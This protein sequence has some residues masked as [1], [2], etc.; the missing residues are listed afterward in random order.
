MEYYVLIVTILVARVS[1]LQK[2]KDEDRI[3]GG[4]YAKKGEFPYAVV[5]SYRPFSSSCGGGI[6]SPLYVLTACHCT[7]T[8]TDKFGSLPE[9]KNGDYSNTRV[10]AGTLARDTPHDQGYQLRWVFRWIQHPQCKPLL[11]GEWIF[12]IAVIQVSARFFFNELVQPIVIPTIQYKL[13]QIVKLYQV[14]QRTCH[15]AGWGFTVAQRSRREKYSNASKYLKAL[16]LRLLPPYYCN[17][18]LCEYSRFYRCTENFALE[19][20]DRVCAAT[21]HSKSGTIC[22][23]DSGSALICGG[24]AVGVVSY[25]SGCT[26]LDDP[27]VYARI[28]AGFNFISQ[29]YIHSPDYIGG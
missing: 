24:V 25:S 7:V 16:A 8:V 14:V 18:L 17:M 3:I 9:R 10:I 13:F 23:G 26:L 12:D 29:Y 1:C 6:L 4:R 21:K 15:V 2:G 20:P 22:G 19:P 5:I 28:D 11:T 27:V